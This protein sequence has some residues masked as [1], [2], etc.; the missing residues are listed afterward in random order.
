MQVIAYVRV[1]TREQADSGAGLGVQR[2]SILEEV[3]R[4]GWDEAEVR[5]EEDAGLSG[6]SLRREG[7]THALATLTRGDV[8]ITSKVD[9]LSRSLLDF[10]GLLDRAQREGWLLL[11]LDAPLDTGTP[12]GEAMV[13]MIAVFAQLERRLIRERT[14]DALAVRKAE[15]VRLGRP[16]RTPPAVAARI[17]R[18]RGKGKGLSA[19]AGVLNDDGVAT[20][21][22]GRRWYAST[23]KSV[24]D[25]A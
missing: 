3:R 19:I 1:S 10:A 12:M 15:G 13:S 8:L 17:R 16:C 22:G 5:W 7:L 25:A 24:L 4:R 6:S 2:A 20:A 9:R 21:L 23:V 11:T 14:K 18:L